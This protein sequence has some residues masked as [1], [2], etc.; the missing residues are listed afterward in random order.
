MVPIIELPKIVRGLI[1]EITKGNNSFTKRV[2]VLLLLLLLLLFII[3]III[4]I[5]V[6]YCGSVSPRASRFPG[7]WIFDWGTGVYKRNR[8]NADYTHAPRTPRTTSTRVRIQFL[9]RAATVNGTRPVCSVSTLYVVFITLSDISQIQCGSMIKNA[10]KCQERFT[11]CKPKGKC[12]FN[13]LV[14]Y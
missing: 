11:E 3:I 8:K 4:I 5:V 14:L 7:F 13:F 12:H 1:E 6:L 9:D 2:F 10:E